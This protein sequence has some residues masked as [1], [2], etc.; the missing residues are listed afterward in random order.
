[1][2]PAIDEIYILHIEPKKQLKMYYTSVEKI[3]INVVAYPL[4]A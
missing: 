4:F 3:L 1:M 2:E